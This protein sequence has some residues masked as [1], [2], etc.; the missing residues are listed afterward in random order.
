M[1]FFTEVIR[2]D[3]R[4]SSPLAC[5]DPALLE[6]NFRAAAAAIIAAAAQAGHHLRLGETFR[7]AP[8]QFSA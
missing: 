2:N 7:S 6:P 1:S 4:F 3:K 5:Y 8:R